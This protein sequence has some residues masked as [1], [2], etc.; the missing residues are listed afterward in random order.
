[1]G[2]SEKVVVI[3]GNEKHHRYKELIKFTCDKLCNKEVVCC[4]LNAC[5][6]H[7]RTAQLLHPVSQQS[8]SRCLKLHITFFFKN[9]TILYYTGQKERLCIQHFKP[10]SKD[11]QDCDVL[12]SVSLR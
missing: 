1:M 2:C 4:A 7:P 11:V 12:P 9:V 10:N 8:M 3:D 5:H 6:I